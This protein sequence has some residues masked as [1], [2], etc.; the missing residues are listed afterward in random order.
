MCYYDY[1]SFCFLLL[2]NHYKSY[3]TYIQ[4]TWV[5]LN[6]T[7]CVF[8]VKSLLTTKRIAVVIV[9]VY[10]ILTSC[11]AP[12]YVVSSLGMKYFPDRNKSM[13]GVVYTSGGQTVEKYFFAINNAFVPLS[14]FVIIIICTVILVFKLSRANKWRKKSSVSLQGDGASSRNQKVSSMVVMI[15][16]L[17]IVCFIPLSFLFIVMSL[18]PELSFDGREKNLLLTIGGC[19]VI[20]ESINSSSNIFIYYKMSTKYRITFRHLV[21]RE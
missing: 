13:L 8:Q 19:I 3:L 7:Y 2:V 11:N 12:V 17:F 4:L 6:S 10:I 16:T 5:K 1:P 9:C 21:C 18:F 14:S 20:M 15:S